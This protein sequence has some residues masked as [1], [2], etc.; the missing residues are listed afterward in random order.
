M[1]SNLNA[2]DWVCFALLIIGALNWGI[3]G[4]VEINVVAQIIEPIFRPDAAELVLRI[5]YTLVG[6]AGL[7]VFYPLFRMS[8]RDHRDADTNTVRDT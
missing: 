4:L 2:L 6:L 7:Y 8:R 3:I 5:I 1:A